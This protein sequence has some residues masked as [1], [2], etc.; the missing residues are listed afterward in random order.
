MRM[1]TRQAINNFI[2]RLGDRADASLVR[3]AW[4]FAT[5]AMT[6][7]DLFQQ[8]LAQRSLIAGTLLVIFI[9]CPAVYSQNSGNSAG[10]KPAAQTI[11][12]LKSDL[13]SIMNE[14]STPGAAVA[15]VSADSII[16]IGTFGFA[17][18]ETG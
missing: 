9:L 18:K 4:D 17:C 15:I 10:Q 7:I 2:S 8:N 5:L 16:W 12:D 14:I 6:R 11:E 1:G 13:D 3:Q